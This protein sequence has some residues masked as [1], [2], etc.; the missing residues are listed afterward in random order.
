VKGFAQI[1]INAV[2]DSDKSLLLEF[3]IN[4]VSIEYCPS[5]GKANSNAK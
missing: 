4:Q 3:I 2:V 5:T 1:T